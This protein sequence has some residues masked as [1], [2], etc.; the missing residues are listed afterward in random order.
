MGDQRSFI[1]LKFPGIFGADMK[2]ERI[3]D[4]HRVITT[5]VIAVLRFQEQDPL[6]F[7]VLGIAILQKAPVWVDLPFVQSLSH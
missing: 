2:F 3:R 6:V 4:V 7:I 5:R 1:L